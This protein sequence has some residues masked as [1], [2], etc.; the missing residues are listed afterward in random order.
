MNKSVLAEG[1]NGFSMLQIDNKFA[2]AVISLYGAQVLSYKPKTQD[3]KELLFVSD[4]AY[5]EQGKAIKGGIPIC[6][7][8]FGDDPL[9]S[10]RPAH[11]F[12]RNTLWQHES[13]TAT[14]QGETQVTL[15]LNDTATTQTLWPH[16]FKLTLIVTI[17]KTLHLSLQTINTDNETFTITQALHTYFAIGDIKHT[18][19]TGLDNIH[20]IDKT[21]ESDIPIK[22]I[23]DIIVD[24]EVDRIYTSSPSTTTLVDEKNKQQISIQSSASNTT[25]VWNPWA[26]G[27]AKM[28]DL[29]DDGYQY[30][31]CV[32]TAN[33]ASD[34]IEIAPTESFE[35]GVEYTVEQIN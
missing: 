8:W 29:N 30:F 16:A 20:Y 2:T 24:Q 12:A 1:K 13:T 28:A 19:V 9:N 17:G 23:G 4:N 22:Q 33:A 7:P 18:R 31:I 10:G 25:V 11:G 32:E 14:K 3:A 5:F 15:S 34:T 35:I 27:A 26:N 6:W 21:I